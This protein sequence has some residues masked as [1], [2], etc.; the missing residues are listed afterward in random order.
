MSQ[1]AYDQLCAHTREGA[2]LRSIDGLLGW[3]QQ[4]KMPPAGGDYR[5]EQCTYLAGMIHKQQ[6][7]ARVGEW[8]DQLADGPLAKD[9]HSETGANIHG[10]K[11][12]Y[13]RKTKLPQ[14]LVEELTRA[15]SLGQQA[16]IE[17]RKANDFK[18]FA[19]HLEKIY[20]LKREEAAALGFAETAYDALLYDYEPEEL[21][22]NI[23]R[24]LSALREELVPLVEAIGASSVQPELDI[25]KRS[26]PV[27]AQ[28]CFGTQAAKQIGFDFNR[29]RLDVTHHPFCGGAGPHDIRM[30]TRYDEHFFNSGFFSIL[31][32]AG[33]GMYEQGL[34]ADQY[35]LPSG[36]AISLG[37]HESQSRMWENLVGRSK[38]CWDY[39]Y[40]LA[41]K[42]FP[43]ALKDVKQDA[44]YFAINHAE[45]TLIRVE[46]DAATYNLHVLIRFELEQA[47]I[48]DQL[49]VADL[50]GAWNEKYQTYL[51]IQPP[52]DA[53]GVLQD[54]HWSAALIGYFPTYS[55]GNL[56]ASQFYEQADADLGGLDALAAKG[57][58][59]P[60]LAWLQKNIHSVGQKYSAAD[61]VEK[62]TKQP[63]SH[64]PLMRHLKK[65]YGE[66]YQL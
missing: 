17:A 16:W 47:L 58:F 30:T 23:T 34:N 42:A 18:T 15:S 51:G 1:A 3:D 46:A 63:L 5:A 26:Y 65:K 59:Q 4:T 48:S 33:H 21:T 27:S 35:G 60:L 12:S 55:L 8:L 29:G 36:E 9:L 61:L 2:L 20:T 11:R 19:P 45:P 43:T 24:V 56:Y 41:Q 50:P 37:I 54:I 39:F 49:K 62:V 13:E 28:E 10:L 7:D 64:A 53:S 44:F 22:S 66:L 25:L 57:E 32:E 31:H 14:R 6:T 38:A 40:P 52:D